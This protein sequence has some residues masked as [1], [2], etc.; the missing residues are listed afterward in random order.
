MGRST[1]NRPDP[2]GDNGL[3]QIDNV[4]GLEVSVMNSKLRSVL[5]VNAM[6]EPDWFALLLCSYVVGIT[7][8]GEIKDTALCAMAIQRNVLELSKGW[9]GSRSRS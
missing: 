6:S 5:A 9:L 7:V 3:A 8:V 4:T 1:C 2:L